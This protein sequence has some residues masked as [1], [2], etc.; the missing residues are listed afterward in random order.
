[1]LDIHS[2]I[3]PGVDDGVQQLEEALQL[4]RCESDGGTRAFIATPHYIEMVDFKKVER[5]VEGFETLKEAVK[6]E[7]IPMDLHL[8]GEI[9]PTMKAFEFIDKGLP[10]TTAGRYVL[11]DLP[12]GPLPNDFDTILY[13]FQLRKL[14]PI[15]AHPERCLGFQT[16]HDRL[17]GLLE[18]G[19]AL[20]VN[21]RSLVGKYGPVAEDLANK[22]L[23]RRWAHF[24]ASD[25][26]RPATK[27]ILRM[28]VDKVAPKLGAEYIELLTVTSAKCMLAGEPLP[29]L[30][31]PPVEEK[32]KPKRWPFGLKLRR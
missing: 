32:E 20:Q 19:M 8:A 4:L 27:P 15:I 2:H 14:T 30:P 28:S 9:Y 16:D 7:G 18:K 31:E 13:E 3:V 29:P 6:S 1:M 12:M 26:H 22:I 25:A 10:L 24:I 21:A 17:Q 5:V 11:V 23:R